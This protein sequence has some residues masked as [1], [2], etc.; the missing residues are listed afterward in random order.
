MKSKEHEVIVKL[1]FDRPVSRGAAIRAAR[2]Q[3]D[4]VG[5]EAFATIDE[6]ERD[7]WTALKITSVKGVRRAPRRK[8]AIL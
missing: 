8:T 7:G 6:E 1:R 2:S 4:P 5:V 3:I